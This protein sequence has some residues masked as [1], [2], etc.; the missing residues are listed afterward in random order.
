MKKIVYVVCAVLA[1]LALANFA[2]AGRNRNLRREPKLIIEKKYTEVIPVLTGEKVLV[3]LTEIEGAEVDEVYFLLVDG[4]LGL[5]NVPVGI[6]RY[7]FDN[8]YLWGLAV[9][10]VDF[11]GVVYVASDS[12]FMIRVVSP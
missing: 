1:G 11:D 5:R 8:V 3:T 6:F 10:E 7:Q 12:P 2:D 4:T 9:F